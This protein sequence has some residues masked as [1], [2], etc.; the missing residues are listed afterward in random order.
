MDFTGQSQKLSRSIDNLVHT[1]SSEQ[2]KMRRSV[3]QNYFSPQ[4]TKQMSYIV[5]E[6]IGAL[7]KLL[8][9]S[10]EKAEPVKASLLFRAMTTDIICEYAFGKSW[11]FIE[12]PEWSEGYFSATQNTFKNIYFFRE[13]P[14]VNHIALAFSQLPEWLFPMGKLRNVTGW[15]E[16]S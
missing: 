8:A 15:A 13:Y 11:H 10:K 5:R 9:E 16:V 6:R 14:V 2:H 12:D 7:C 4:K 3:I 1:V